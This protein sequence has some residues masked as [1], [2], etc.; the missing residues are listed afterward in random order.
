MKKVLPGI[1]IFVAL[2]IAIAVIAGKGEQQQT[3]IS[4]APPAAAPAKLPEKE[5]SYNQYRYWVG[6]PKDNKYAVT[7]QPF[8]ERNDA[9]VMGALRA[10]TTTAYGQDVLGET[11]PALDGTGAI[12][13]DTPAGR[14]TF[15][16]TKED[17]GQVNGA[18]FRKE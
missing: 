2:L 17:T 7:F 5:G 11:V 12:V 13:Y 15:L 14:Y 10:V 1:G 8:L 18:S 4:P 6:G 16:I 3:K 9:T